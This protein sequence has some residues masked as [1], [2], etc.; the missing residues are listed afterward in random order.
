M[1]KEICRI[2]VLKRFSAFEWA[3][4]ILVGSFILIDDANFYSKY[5]I[6]IIFISTFLMAFLSN[7]SFDEAKFIDCNNHH[8]GELRA[9]RYFDL[10][11]Y[12]ILISL[13]GIY[14][15]FWGLFPLL[16]TMS[17]F[18][19]NWLAG[20]T[21]LVILVIAPAIS[22]ISWSHDLTKNPSKFL[23]FIFK[24]IKPYEL[25]IK[26]IEDLHCLKLGKKIL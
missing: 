14:A 4:F 1:E 24:L 11:L 18:D 9:R 3:F 2:H 26:R 13:C 6:A 19:Y 7:I 12:I 23:S 17:M 22:A 8:V 5:N 10:I 20:L 16:F 25:M 15:L 21:S